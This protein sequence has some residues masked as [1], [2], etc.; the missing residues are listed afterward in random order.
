MEEEL[1]QRFDRWYY[2]CRS[3]KMFENQ[4]SA[5]IHE[6]RPEEITK[7]KQYEEFEAKHSRGGR[8]GYKKYISFQVDDFSRYDTSIKLIV[9][10]NDTRYELQ[11]IDRDLNDIT[12]RVYGLKQNQIDG[13]YVAL[14]T[15]DDGSLKNHH[16]Y[17]VDIVNNGK[18]YGLVCREWNNL[19]I[20]NTQIK[21]LTEEQVNALL[22]KNDLKQL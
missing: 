14:I 17:E 11:I 19:Q 20:V 8:S 6:M 16:M 12:E 5:M 1:K 9:L 21:P 2:S 7:F 3:F 10:K 18:K 4:L 22:G 13:D 15:V